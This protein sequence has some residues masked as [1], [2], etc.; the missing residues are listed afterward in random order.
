M[1]A[2]ASEFIKNRQRFPHAHLRFDFASSNMSFDKLD[3]NLFIAG[4]LEIISDTKTGNS[5][6]KG[7]LELL[8]KLMY[9][10]NSYEFSTIKSLY[11]AA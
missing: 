11:A 7:R 1:T 9:L 6:R 8:K 3:F 4:E 5:E 2:K 10:S